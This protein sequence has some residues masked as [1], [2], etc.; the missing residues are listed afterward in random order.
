MLLASKPQILLELSCLTANI[1][2]KINSKFLSNVTEYKDA[3]PPST[4]RNPRLRTPDLGE[5]MDL[6]MVKLGSIGSHDK[7]TF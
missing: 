4:I 5:E 7:D 6:E 2:I 3:F 1:I